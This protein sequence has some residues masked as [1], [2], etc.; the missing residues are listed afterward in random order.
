M[1]KDR[2]FYIN[3]GGYLMF[4]Q[5]LCGDMSE[6]EGFPNIFTREDLLA[7]DWELEELT[8]SVKEKALEDALEFAF[9]KSDIKNMSSIK[10]TFFEKLNKELEIKND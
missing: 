1:T 7:D 3:Q 4:K 9:F 5:E 8:L 10:K 2:W 6:C